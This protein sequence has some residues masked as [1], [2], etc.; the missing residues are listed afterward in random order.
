MGRNMSQLGKDERELVGSFE[1]GEWKQVPDAG[2]EVTRHREYAET[3]M[4]EARHL[5]ER[6]HD[7][8]RLW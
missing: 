6:R 5:R 2:A 8:K 1:A 7:E 4:E 3:T